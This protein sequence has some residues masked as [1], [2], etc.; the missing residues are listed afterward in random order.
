MSTAA[1]ARHAVVVGAGAVG[2]ATALYLRREGFAVTVLDPQ[3]PGEGAS[4]GNAG[5]LAT[6]SVIPVGTPEVLKRL[7]RMMLD[8]LAPVAV[9]WRYLPRLTPWF[10]RFLMASR[11][12][13]VEEISRALAALLAH[14]HDAY[15][16]LIEE[17]GAGDLLRPSGMLHVYENEAAYRAGE[18]G[19]ALR[20][21]RG[22]PYDDL[23]RDELRQLVPALAPEV[24]HGIF[25]RDPVMTVDPLALVQALAASL[26]AKG[27]VI[28]R[29]RVTGFTD[30]GGRPAGVTTETAS[31]AADLIVIAAGAFSRPLAKALGSAVPLDTERGYHVMLPDPGIEL[32]LPVQCAE[33]AF[34]LTPMAKGLRLAGTDELAGLEAPPNWDRAR[35]LVERARRL[36]P[37]L[38]TEGLEPWMGFRPSL[39]DSLP[40]L[41]RAPGHDNVYFAFGH[42]HLGLTMAAASGRIIAELAS[43]RDP[44]IDL[45]PYRAERF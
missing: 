4:L 29:E 21:R 39:P 22:V 8:P 33:G 18:E 16:P 43:G 17:A 45:A 25:L 36:F 42:G 41:G 9:R 38:R 19:R 44:G 31:H 13:R 24:A 32:R 23:G 14:T 35:V 20:A 27:G 26:E 30:A 10:L 11:P 37:G 28:R 2:I 7:P 12:G 1:G 5:I 6:G 40:V 34:V 15:R 3:A